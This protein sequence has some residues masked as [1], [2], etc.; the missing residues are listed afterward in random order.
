M[1][2]VSLDEINGL[3]DLTIRELAQTVAEVVGF[4]GALVCDPSHPDG[5]PRKLLD[6]SR[7]T[8]LGWQAE[9][10]LKQGLQLTYDWF[11][12]SPWSRQETA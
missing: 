6:I 12:R 9:I 5:T 8:Q 10:P 1:G 3:P 4:Q 2:I 7:I 11:C